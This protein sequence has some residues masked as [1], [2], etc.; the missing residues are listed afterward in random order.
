[1]LYYFFLSVEGL[2]FLLPVMELLQFSFQLKHGVPTVSTRK[3]N[4][5][6]TFF[7]ANGREVN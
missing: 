2:A 7:P 6:N 3:R 4:I 5:S 1:M